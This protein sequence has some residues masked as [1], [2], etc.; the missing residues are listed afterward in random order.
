MTYVSGNISSAWRMLGWLLVALT[1]VTVAASPHTRGQAPAEDDDPEENAP[2]QARFELPEEQFDQWLFQGQSTLAAGRTRLETQLRL[3]LEGI[4]RV[5][6]LSDDQRRKLQ[7]AGRGDVKRFFDRVEDVRLKFREVRK[8]QNKVGEIFQRIQP[9]QQDL[10]A[11]LFG[12]VSLFRRVLPR[13][14]TADQFATYGKVEQQ[15]RQFHYQ[16][17]V[18][19]AVAMLENALPMEDEQRQKLKRLILAETKP[20]KR[21]SPHDYHVVLVQL[22]KISEAKLKPIF[23]D[24][25]WKQMSR[26]KAQMQGMEQFL[27][28]QG[29]LP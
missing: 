12:D 16:A 28:Q 4:D 19:L 10:Q 8:D 22:A 24:D 18:G 25:Q 21:F 6:Q 27:K 26:Q 14:L 7:L 9:L 5:C 1:V 23:D 11:G 29:V 15:R 20:P 2:P 3:H 17:K 13:I